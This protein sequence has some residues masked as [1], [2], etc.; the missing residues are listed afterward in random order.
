MHSGL[1][2]VLLIIVIEKRLP[3]KTRNP[4]GKYGPERYVETHVWSDRGI[5]EGK[6]GNKGV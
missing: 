1:Y 6:S 5:K 4:D 2:D 3:D